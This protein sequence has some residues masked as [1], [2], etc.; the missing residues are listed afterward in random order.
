MDT[1]KYSIEKFKPT[2]IIEIMVGD[3]TVPV[4]TA[5][6]LSRLATV[7]KDI[8]LDLLTKAAKSE[9]DTEKYA[10]LRQ[11]LKWVAEYRHLNV[12][13]HGMTKGV[14]ERAMMKGFEVQGN[15]YRELIKK[16]P[17]DRIVEIVNELKKN[18]NSRND[19]KES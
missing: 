2:K 6:E 8:I 12:A 9:D 1:P 17:D 16:L 3:L 14:Q 5:S 11:A 4:D 19:S 18:G 10:N 7:E 13:I 15:L